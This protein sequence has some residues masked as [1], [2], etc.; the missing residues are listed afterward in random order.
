MSDTPL[1]SDGVPMTARAMA[2]DVIEPIL[3]EWVDNA[4][5]LVNATHPGEAQDIL[6]EIRWLHMAEPWLIANKIL[7][8]LE[9]LMLAL[10]VEAIEVTG[11][12]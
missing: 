5:A 7:T 6:R 9:P 10:A 1:D 3:T 11:D 4:C 2:F 12:A 8:S